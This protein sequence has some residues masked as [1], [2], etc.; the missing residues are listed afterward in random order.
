M[1]GYTD[2]QTDRHIPHWHRE[3]MAEWRS[4]FPDNTASSS[5]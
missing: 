1:D 2:R 4:K 5:P 3:G